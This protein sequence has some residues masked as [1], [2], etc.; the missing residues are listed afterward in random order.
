MV[1]DVRRVINHPKEN[2]HRVTRQLGTGVAC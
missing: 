2:R 1:M